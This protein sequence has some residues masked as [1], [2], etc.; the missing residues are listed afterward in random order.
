MFFMI[1]KQHS[2]HKI[3][4]VLKTWVDF[5]FYARIYKP[6]KKTTHSYDENEPD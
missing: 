5:S 6:S 3:L 2:I 1:T 4:K